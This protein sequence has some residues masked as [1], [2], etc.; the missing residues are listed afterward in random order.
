[1]TRALPAAEGASLSEV[2]PPFD[3][4]SPRQQSAIDCVLCTRRL[5]MN[6]RVLGEARHRGFVFR[7]W[8]C[9]P[10]CRAAP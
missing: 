7:L 9:T 5:G 10:G 3:Q 1:M 2:L 4:L 8:G 6:G